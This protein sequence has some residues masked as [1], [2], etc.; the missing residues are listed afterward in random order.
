MQPN[1]DNQN[2]NVQA[3]S[4]DG[5]TYIPLATIV[6][7]LGGRIDWDNTAKKATLEVRGQ[8]AEVDINDSLVTVNGQER[9][10]AAMPFVEDGRLYV[11]PD[12]LDQL[13]LTHS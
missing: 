1:N 6:H 4:K 7:Q 12:F 9:G 2:A 10:L 13:G 11:T 3:I 8:T 5:T